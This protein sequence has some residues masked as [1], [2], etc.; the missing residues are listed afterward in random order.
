[1]SFGIALETRYMH[2]NDILEKMHEHS[3]YKDSSPQYK[4]AAK[5]VKQL[6][7]CQKFQ[8]RKIEHMKVC[9]SARIQMLDNVVEKNLKFSRNFGSTSKKSL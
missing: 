5:Y 9:Y 1:M 2:E 6:N 7:A 4:K 3:F 8:T